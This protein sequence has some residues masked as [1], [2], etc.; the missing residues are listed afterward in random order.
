MDY[1][2][3]SLVV[4]AMGATFVVGSV[5]VWVTPSLRGIFQHHVLVDGPRASFFVGNT[6]DL[7]CDMQFH[8]KYLSWARE[9]GD[10]MQFTT[11]GTW[12]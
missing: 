10:V 11:L 1:D 5:V 8:R 9:Y 6:S 3:S 4:A 7:D 12:V 2:L